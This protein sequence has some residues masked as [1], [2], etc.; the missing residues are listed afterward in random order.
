M[1]LVFDCE[2]NGLPDWHKPSEDPGQPHIVQLAAV[3]RSRDRNDALKTLLNRLIKPGDWSISTEMTA[4]HGISM[5]RACDEGLPVNDV[6]DEFLALA[7]EAEALIGYNMNF[8]K[9]M[10]RIQ[11][12]RRHGGE[13]TDDML[14]IGARFSGL[15]DYELAHRMTA[16]CQLAPTDKMMVAGRKTAKTPKLG[17]AFAHAYPNQKLPGKLHDAMIDIRATLA[18]YW[19]LYDKGEFSECA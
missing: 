9:R 5:E 10:I 19:W 6:L 2:T 1:L 14:P 17:E 11:E 13:T 12:K 4:I 16:H 3:L 15:V 8:D 18:L 7:N